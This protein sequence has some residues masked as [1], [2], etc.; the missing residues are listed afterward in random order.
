MSFYPH[1][2]A[3]SDPVFSAALSRKRPFYPHFR[4]GSDARPSLIAFS[5]ASFLPALPRGK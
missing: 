1:F 2:R 3:G 5:K 4:A